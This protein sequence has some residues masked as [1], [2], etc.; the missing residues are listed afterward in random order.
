MLRDFLLI[1]VMI[2]VAVIGYYCIKAVDRFLKGNKT[3]MKR[4][5]K[6]EISYKNNEE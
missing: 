3:A 1:C 6:D 4:E 2:P 5:G